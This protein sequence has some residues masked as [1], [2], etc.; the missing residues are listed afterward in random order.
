MGVYLHSKTHP[1]VIK[2]SNGTS[3]QCY[4]YQYH[5]FLCFST[6]PIYIHF[7]SKI[8]VFTCFHSSLNKLY[9]Y[10][11]DPFP[12]KLFIHP[13]KEKFKSGHV[14]EAFNSMSFMSVLNLV[15]ADTPSYDARCLWGT[16]YPR[17]KC[18]GTAFLGRSVWWTIYRRHKIFSDTGS[19]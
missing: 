9:I 16:I 12:A 10:L 14:E 13:S 8:F 2:Y 17:T 1:L 18:P 4:A 6:I 3:T 19:Y 11:L 5:Y 15:L 7:Y